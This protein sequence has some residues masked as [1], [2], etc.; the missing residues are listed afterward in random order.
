MQTWLRTMLPQIL[1]RSC[2]SWAG[3]GLGNALLRP[4]GTIKPGVAASIVRR[5]LSL[6]TADAT[7]R[8]VGSGTNAASNAE[9]FVQSMS[10]GSSG[11]T[12]GD[13]LTW[14]SVKQDDGSLPI[15]NP[16]FYTRLRKYPRAAE[17]SDLP[18]RLFIRPPPVDEVDKFYTKLADKTAMATKEDVVRRPE[19]Y[20]WRLSVS[21]FVEE[22]DL[23]AIG[24]DTS[25]ERAQV[26]AAMHML[27]Q[28]HGANLLHLLANPA[29]SAKATPLVEEP[30]VL[31][32]EAADPVISGS[33]LDTQLVLGPPM[34]SLDASSKLHVYNYAA[35]FGLIPQF[36]FQNTAGGQVVANLSLPN[37]QVYTTACGTNQVEAETLACMKFK[38]A[39]EEKQKNVSTDVLVLR[40]ANTVN[41]DNAGHIL[42]FYEATH[43]PDK[44]RW[45]L[46]PEKG[47]KGYLNSEDRTSA[48]LYWRGQ[49]V[50][51]AIAFAG[52]SKAKQLTSLV[53]AVTLTQRDQNLLPD[54]FAAVEQNGGRP[55]RLIPPTPV[56]LAQSAET[57]LVETGKMVEGLDLD[58][59]SHLQ[60]SVEV[61]RRP[62]WL[63]NG[64]FSRRYMK[65]HSSEYSRNQHLKLRQETD[66]QDPEAQEKKQDS[67]GLPIQA[68]KAEIL[69]LVKNN[70]QCI[71]V[72]SAACGKS[73][74]LPQIILDDAIAEGRG[75][76]CNII[77][78]T[79]RRAAAS[80]L[81]L[82]VAYERN[83]NLREVIG[84][85]IAGDYQRCDLDGSIN[86]L[87]AE[88]LTMQL[89]H[90][91]DDTIDSLS[92]IIIDEVHE[93]NETTNR[94]MTILKMVFSNRMACGASIPKL[95]LMSAT[96]ESTMFEHYFEL[97]D[98]S[99][100]TLR[101]PV[102]TIPGR[103]FPI[104]ET[105]LEGVLESVKEGLQ[106][107]K[108][109]LNHQLTKRYLSAELDGDHQPLDTQ[110]PSSIDWRSSLELDN[111]HTAHKQS[112]GLVVATIVNV[113]N[114]TTNGDVLVFLP[115]WS[116][117]LDVRNL[118]YDSVAE[119][120]FTDR[121]KFAIVL[122]HSVNPDGIAESK[123]PVP[124]GCRRILLSSNLAETSHTFA[125]AKYVV[126]S[127]QMKAKEYMETSMDA[128][129]NRRWVSKSN[130][131]QRAGRIGRRQPGEYFALFS[132]R[133]EVTMA[134]FAKVQAMSMPEIE[135][136]CLR[137]RRHFPAIPVR[138]F[139]SR[140]LSI[141]P[142][143][144]IN[145]AIANLQSI[146]AFT[147]SE[148]ITD[149]GRA[150]NHLIIVT[151]AQGRM[152][153]LG[154]LFRCVDPL[155][156]MAAMRTTPQDYFAPLLTTEFLSGDTD[157]FRRL[158]ARGTRSDIIAIINA[159]REYM[160]IRADQ[161]GEDANVWATQNRLLP[162][163]LDEAGEVEQSIGRLLD[164]IGYIG[165]EAVADRKLLNTR[166]ENY[167]LVKSLLMTGMRPHLAVHDRGYNFHTD[168]TG[169][170]RLWDASLMRAVAT[171][172][173]VPT[174]RRMKG[175]ICCYHDL[176]FGGD[177]FE[178]AVIAGTSPVPPLGAIIFSNSLK[179][180]EDDDTVLIIDGWLPVQILGE[181]SAA[182]SLLQFKQMC[183]KVLNLALQQL[184][185]P[186]RIASS[187]ALELMIQTISDLLEY[188]EKRWQKHMDHIER[189]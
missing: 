97:I 64:Q 136:T 48:E 110:T 78:T 46:R 124:S 138:Q 1:R 155:M 12:S 109:T 143:G 17:Y 22:V 4:R 102:C 142:S 150:L 58:H 67:L 132:K 114:T 68:V 153:L 62:D 65:L 163:K 34:R 127:G 99:G 158:H 39:A 180:K 113:V 74:Q 24:E 186:R 25:K 88:L 45:R 2:I 141:P 147:E 162:Q 95:V 90:M 148:D 15:K 18:P 108:S 107:L 187:P 122:L 37:L 14:F 171:H 115:G 60:S 152:I 100:S 3:H 174:L 170:A 189:R 56:A 169:G 128:V 131:A 103:Q 111:H 79:P 91:P 154:T 120:D 135:E 61:K 53:G 32:S 123:I 19:G 11:F 30:K 10:P 105:Y 54:F 85:H 116:D 160:K 28:L 184:C 117:I 49:L 168:A 16:E 161:S 26:A 178:K 112:L 72:G 172:S 55:P 157:K 9:K 6:A 31:K 92:H 71:V 156:A 73:T 44:F 51:P 70:L 101:P 149:L 126:D 40:G 96:M 66:L 8:V 20:L 140:F 83:E 145:T 77:I 89:E 43:S 47:T 29:L 144:Y 121:N 75:A 59:R 129:L 118:L 35:H 94:L 165:R 188:D 104:K 50:A 84:Y 146:N 130:L 82:R 76:A 159:Y 167:G 106:P 27:H 175:C 166:S 183:D 80:E 185:G 69:S 119:F 52:S 13:A 173:T 23:T 81:G 182:R 125:D 134:P 36:E 87:T 33:Q 164:Q 57:L 133:R 151:P 63:Q 98:S 21:V 179:L 139:V 42:T 5:C 86:F 41:M 137:A 7:R 93:L 177:G 38:E 176:R 181:A